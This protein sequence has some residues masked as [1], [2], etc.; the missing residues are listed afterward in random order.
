MM[1][2]LDAGRVV[3]FSGFLIATL[4]F[5][6]MAWQTQKS[7]PDDAVIQQ[8]FMEHSIAASL[9]FLG[10]LL[11]SIYSVVHLF[12][13]SQGTLTETPFTVAMFF[14]LA[15]G[16]AFMIHMIKEQTPKHPFYIRETGGK[17]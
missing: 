5:F 11:G 13:L 17:E 14:L 3:M 6:W 10:S 9:A 16:I 8:H 2:I 7:H 15:S 1:Y 12:S 4:K